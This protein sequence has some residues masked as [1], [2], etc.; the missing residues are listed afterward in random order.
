MSLRIALTLAAAGLALA[1]CQQVSDE[2]FGRKVRAYLLEHPE[3]L[4][5]VGQKLE[6]KR[7]AQAAE[8]AKAGYAKHRK[9]LE[10]DP[11][12]FV[13]NPNG[14]VTVV[15]FYDYKCGW[16]KRIA[17]E[18]M[19]LIRENPDVRFVFKEYPIF[20]GESDQAAAI[21]ASPAARPKVLELHPRLMG[22]KALDSAAV[23]RHLA[24]V[25]LDPAA[26]RKS[27]A[28]PEVAQ[29][30]ADNHRL[31]A[32]LGIEGTPHFVVGE[33]VISGADLAAL[34]M[35]IGKARMAAAG[36]QAEQASGAAAG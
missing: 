20:G 8:L 33:Q 27:A 19:T 3:V 30:L 16:C 10:Q 5:E 26:V 25:G 31:A 15:E 17:P 24:A 14:K 7:T 2:A 1:G 32:A 4:V 21:M 23:D 34:R 35:A 22:E 11:R 18:I 29:H 9:A 36:R 13:A 6:E 28:S 12:D